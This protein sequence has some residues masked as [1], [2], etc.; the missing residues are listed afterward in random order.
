MVS[1]TRIARH[2]TARIK[3]MKTVPYGGAGHHSGSGVHAKPI[4]PPRRVRGK[5]R[6]ARSVGKL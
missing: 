1:K 2:H 3:V 5:V 4:A 6:S